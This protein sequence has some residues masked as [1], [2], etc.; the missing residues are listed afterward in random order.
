MDQRE[1]LTYLVEKLSKES[2]QKKYK[3]LIVGETEEEQKQA[4]HTLTNVRPVKPIS[5]DILKIQD[6]FLQE[7]AKKKGI[8]TLEDIPTVSEELGIQNP[9]SDKISVWQGDITRL[10]VDAIVNAANAQMLGCFVPCHNCI[11][12]VIHSAAGIQLRNE[13]ANKM[14]EKKEQYGEKYK[15]PRGQA[16]ITNGYNLPAKYVIHTVGPIFW[17][18]VRKKHKELLASCYRS[19]LELAE[20]Y[21]LQSIAFC[22]ISTGRY[23]L[24]GHLAAKVAIETVQN[25]Y[26]ETGSHIR[27]IFDVFSERDRIFYEEVLQKQ[28]D[29]N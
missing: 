2:D 24:P 16:M 28:S 23:M 3:N 17:G 20:K 6:D 26:K 29:E 7:E 4:L 18:I 11:D 21:K 8:V 19:C 10:K 1:R 27:V 15:E 5:P 14:N 25:Y 22:C 13:C 12:N 9:F